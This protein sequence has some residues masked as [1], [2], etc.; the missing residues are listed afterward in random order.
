MTLFRLL[1]LAL[2]TLGTTARADTCLPKLEL[3][4]EWTACTADADCALAGDG[5][6]TCGN[7]LPV[8]AKFKAE[9]TKKDLDARAAAKCVLTCEA[10]AAA[11]VKLTC[12]AGQCKAAKRA[13]PP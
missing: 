3:P 6:R 5:C 13:P 8:N 12:E 11:A 4:K 7:W 10:C 1:L 2:L 9:A